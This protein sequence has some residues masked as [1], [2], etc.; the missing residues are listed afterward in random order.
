VDDVHELVFVLG[1][2]LGQREH[3]YAYEFFLPLGIDLEI[4]IVDLVPA[5]VAV[6]TVE[7]V[8]LVLEA[9]RR[10][11][12]VHDLQEME[13]WYFGAEAGCNLAVVAVVG[14]DCN[15]VGVVEHHNPLVAAVGQMEMA[16]LDQTG[17]E[18]H[19]VGNLMLG[20]LDP[21]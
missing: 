1:V 18:L 5:V 8:D 14:A 4:H 15:L 17:W 3:I 2:R 20:V 11:A 9:G 12:V 6:E 10:M 16:H 19:T 7:L 21:D 13:D